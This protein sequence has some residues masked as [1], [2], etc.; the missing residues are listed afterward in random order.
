MGATPR[1]RAL[2]RGRCRVGA[3]ACPLSGGCALTPAEWQSWR[4]G[5]LSLWNRLRPVPGQPPW[6]GVLEK[7]DPCCFTFPGFPAPTPVGQG[8][9]SDP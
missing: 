2:G 5:T 3:A 1:C 4:R 8:T 6:P 9:V 7:Q